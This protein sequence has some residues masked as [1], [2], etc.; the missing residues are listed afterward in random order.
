MRYTF[1]AYQNPNTVLDHVWMQVHKL[2]RNVF[3]SFFCFWTAISSLALIKRIRHGWTFQ[4]RW[5]TLGLYNYYK[6]GIGGL[7][8]TMCSVCYQTLAQILPLVSSNFMCV[9]AAHYMLRVREKHLELLIMCVVCNSVHVVKSVLVL[10]CLCLFF[11][12]CSCL[13]LHIILSIYTLVCVSF[14]SRS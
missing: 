13:C 14:S 3:F 1:P 11:L 7:S 5:L 9:Y 12:A 2:H 8:S 4:S 6:R 10:S